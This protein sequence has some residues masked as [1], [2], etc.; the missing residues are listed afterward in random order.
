MTDLHVTKGTQQENALTHYCR[1]F[2][3]MTTNLQPENLN[4]PTNSTLKKFI[5]TR[6]L[7][8]DPVLV[9]RSHPHFGLNLI[10][11][12]SDHVKIPRELSPLPKTNQ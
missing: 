11:Y 1:Q 5:L 6:E 8:F 3:A 12:R 7:I 10:P 4:T 9:L 2:D